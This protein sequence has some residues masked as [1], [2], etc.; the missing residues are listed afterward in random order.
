MDHAW[1]SQPSG[2]KGSNLVHV[3][4]LNDPCVPPVKSYG[5]LKLILD[6]PANLR[7]VAIEAV[8]VLRQGKFA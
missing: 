7:V 4:P 3:M 6:L 2:Q 1:V 5:S 8:E